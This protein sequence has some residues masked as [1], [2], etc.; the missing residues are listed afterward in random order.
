M[1]AAGFWIE[2]VFLHALLAVDTL[3][4]SWPGGSGSII[5]HI[6]SKTPE[7]RI[8]SKANR[9]YYDMQQ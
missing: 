2:N 9:L 6:G 5:Q 7:S 3:V 1:L 8:H 4:R